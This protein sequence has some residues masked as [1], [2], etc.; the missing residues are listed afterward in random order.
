MGGYELG[1]FKFSF[2][3]IPQKKPSEDPSVK[4]DGSGF[5]SGSLALCPPHGVV[6]GMCPYTGQE[7]RVCGG[8]WIDRSLAGEGERDPEMQL[9]G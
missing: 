5:A 9:E 3:Q 1:L 7:R 8:R 4:A 2:E 6:R